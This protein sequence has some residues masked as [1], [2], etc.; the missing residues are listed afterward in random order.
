VGR[1]HPIP[2]KVGEGITLP[3][4]WNVWGDSHQ[5]V[6]PLG[7]ACEVVLLEDILSAHKVAQVTQ[8]IPLFGTRVY[9]K[10]IKY[11]R[12]Q[13]KPIIVWLDK[14]QEDTMPAVCTRLGLLTGQPVRYIT[15]DKDPKFYTA[16]EIQEILK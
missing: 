14:D 15:T 6:Q 10:T 5:S 4:K 13:K 2:S 3:R 1:H 12:E 9:P 16:S 11:L 8:T 7:E